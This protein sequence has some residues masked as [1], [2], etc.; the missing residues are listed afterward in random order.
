MKIEHGGN[1]RA[2]AERYG[3]RESELLDFSANINPHPLP[4]DLAQLVSD[5]FAAVKH[6]PDPDYKRLRGI[7]AG[8]HEIDPDCIVLGNGVSELIPA[9]K[10]ALQIAATERRQVLVNVLGQG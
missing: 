4:A 1:L 2:A 3:I 7:L 8:Y 10:R 6:Y 9:L 5:S